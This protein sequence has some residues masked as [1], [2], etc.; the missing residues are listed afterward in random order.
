MIS[1]PEKKIIIATHYLLYGAAQAL[2]EYLNKKKIAKL[3]YIAHPLVTQRQTLCVSFQEGKQVAKKILHRG[4]ALSVLDYVCDFIL[5]LWFVVTQETYAIFVGVDGLNCLAGLLLRK[6]GKVEQ[7]IF[8]SI[9]FVPMR[10]Q[11]ALLNKIYH[12]IELFCIKHADECW[13][14]SP[15][16]AQG[17]EKFLHLS[18]QTYP[19]TVVPIG[20]WNNDIKK[21]SFDQIKKQ[22]VLFMGHLLEKQGVQLVLEAIPAIVKKIPE[23][24][25]LIVGGGEYMQALQQQVERL[26]IETYV[27]FC[28]WITERATIDAMMSESAMAIATYMPEKEQLYNFT[29]YADPTKLKDYLGAGLPIILT[30]ISYNAKE[31]AEKKCGIV[32]SYTKK[33]ITEAIITLLKNEKMLQM[34]RKNAEKYA[35][36]FDWETIF[37]KAFTATSFMRR[38]NTMDTVAHYK[39]QLKYFDSE[40]SQVQAYSLVA[41]QKSYI[42]KI[43]TFML[44]ADVKNKTFLDIATGRGYVA[45]EMAKL[46]FKKVIACDLS[47]E[48]IKN[49]Q[50]YKEQFKLKNLELLE[51]KAEEIPLENDSVD[52]IVANAILEHIPNEQ[53]AINQWKRLLKKNGKMLITVP[54]KF[55]Y[56]WPFLWTVNKWHDKRIGHLRRYDVY[57]LQHKFQLKLLHY[58]YTGH[59]IKVFGIFVSMLARSGTYDDIFELLDKKKE[60]V[61]YGANNVSVVLQK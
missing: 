42:E 33:D 48:S 51:C 20:I 7:V 1:L 12:K 61:R 13:N 40:F 29:Y 23:F 60:H 44:D 45:I 21:R 9:D 28:G 39:K 26:Q 17:R 14:V 54:L 5:T 32:V 49:L 22:Q 38:N 55:E 35:Q 58:F 30:D 34:Y 56:I 52:Y 15:R 10:F 3:L 46:G 6:M 36:S 24:H 2:C 47:P 50:V 25:F 4:K 8:Y 18:Q 16:I 27:T 11:N 57:D 41:W 43:K 59:L 31:I 37:D 53:Q 19:Q